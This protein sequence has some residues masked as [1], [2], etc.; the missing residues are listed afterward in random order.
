MNRF[1][2]VGVGKGADLHQRV[3]SGKDPSLLPEVKDHGSLD[4][5]PRINQRVDGLFDVELVAASQWMAPIALLFVKQVLDVPVLVLDL[6]VSDNADII[7]LE[8]RRGIRG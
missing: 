2:V 6:E 5:V 1:D 8:M 4:V 7:W 3:P